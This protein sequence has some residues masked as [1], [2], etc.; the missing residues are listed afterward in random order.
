MS[1]G[2]PLLLRAHLY[3]S[4]LLHVIY[5]CFVIWG[6]AVWLKV[7]RTESGTRPVPVTVPAT[8]TAEVSR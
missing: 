5:G 4:A 6:F 1:S 2:V 7:S 3:P 8:A